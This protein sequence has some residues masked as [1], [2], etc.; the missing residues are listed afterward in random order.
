MN[1]IV[2][3]AGNENFVSIRASS[4]EVEV[5][6]PA[7]L[8]RLRFVD[9]AKAEVQPLA[10]DRIAKRPIGWNEHPNLWPDRLVVQDLCGGEGC[11][12]SA[13]QRAESKALH[14]THD[15]RRELARAEQNI[16]PAFKRAGSTERR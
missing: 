3:V 11:N 8:I 16:G 5:G 14:D 9:S 1:K 7:V 10:S 12:N 6:V 15:T 2:R 13:Y 4:Y